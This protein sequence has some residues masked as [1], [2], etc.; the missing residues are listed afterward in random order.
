MS[1]THVIVGVKTCGKLH[2]ARRRYFAAAV[3]D[4]HRIS[5]CPP[6]AFVE[7]FHAAS[8]EDVKH[9]DLVVGSVDVS[10]NSIFAL[11]QTIAHGD[12]VLIRGENV[13]VVCP[14]LAGDFIC[15]RFARL[16]GGSQNR[17]SA[18]G[19]LRERLLG[20]EVE[21]EVI[22]KQWHKLQRPFA[23]LSANDSERISARQS[24]IIDAVKLMHGVNASDIRSRSMEKPSP[25]SLRERVAKPTAPAVAPIESAVAVRRAAKHTPSTPVGKVKAATAPIAA[26]AKRKR[27]ASLTGRAPTPTLAPIRPSTTAHQTTLV[28]QSPKAIA[29]SPPETAS[30]PLLT[31]L[32]PRVPV[33][34]IS[35]VSSSGINTVGLSDVVAALIAQGA[36]TVTF[37]IGPI[38]K[39]NRFGS[40]LDGRTGLRQRGRMDADRDTHCG[41][42]KMDQ[43]PLSG[44]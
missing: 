7:D 2:G 32:Q 18:I 42:K 35:A 44:G 15:L 34:G 20:D 1:L 33:S 28:L 4:V 40:Y 29:T 12:A 30:T 21:C 38:P 14:F 36:R 31:P 13:V 3:A 16:F 17:L 22:E 25:Y 11:S 27:A 41:E 6:H 26:S 23:S 19:I 39:P 37:D 9:H 5:A 10:R 24:S 43:P 8:G